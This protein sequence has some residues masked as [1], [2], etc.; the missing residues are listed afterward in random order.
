MDT[1]FKPQIA[2][3]EK[4][5]VES[6]QFEKLKELITYLKSHSP[7]YQKRL[8]NFELS[9]M[10]SL[11]DLALLPFTTKEDINQYNEDFF[12]VSKRQIIDYVTTSGTLGDP[13]N[14]VAST[15]DLDRLAYNEALSF[16]CAGCNENSIIQ[17]MT[18]IDKRFMAG[19]AYFLGARMLGAGVIRVGAGMPQLQWDT[20]KRMQPDT[21]VAVPSFIV[22]LI[23]YAEANHIDY[24]NSSVKRAI[25]IG[26]PLRNQDFSLNILGKRIQEKWNIQLHSTYASTEMAT[27]FTECE[28]GVGGHQQIELIIVELIDENGKIVAD[29]E[30]GELVITT[31]GIEAMPLLRFKT[32][33]ICRAHTQTCACGRTSLRLGPVAGRK[34]QM[35]KFKGTTL[36]P[37]AIFD[38]L[39]EIDAIDLYQ[40]E[41]STNEIG[42]DDVCVKIALKKDKQLNEKELKDYF[43]SRLRVSPSVHFM[44]TQD[45]REQ[46]FKEENRK[47]ILLLD[48]R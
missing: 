10:N 21:L 5:E 11:A 35:I 16:A 6:F 4:S 8:K 9:K 7:F 34:K 3:A 33:D 1:K 46:V 29:G 27:A 14:I 19:L 47:P 23:E 43:R 42:M 36:F 12:A 17:L 28:Y 41:L 20:I 38:V 22:K 45:L 13:V 40:V 31:L 25:C 30:F 48:N 26:E 15:A 37:G 44:K 2:F 24:K 18:T 39:N 32:G